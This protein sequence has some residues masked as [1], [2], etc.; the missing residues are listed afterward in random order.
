MFKKS[1]T[2]LKH[3][4][5]RCK[6]IAN[7]AILNAGTLNKIGKLLKLTA[8]ATHHYIDIVCIQEHRYYYSE[9]E[10]KYNDTGNE[11]TFISVSAWK[12]SV[13]AIIE[14]VEL[15]KKLQ[16]PVSHQP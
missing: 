7:I 9:L 2:E 16:H 4:L 10:I 14:E 3:K 5:L 15:V 1:A 8:S 6:C 12:I 13:I 11:W